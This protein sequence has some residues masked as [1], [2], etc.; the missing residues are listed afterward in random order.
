[1]KIQPVGLYPHWLLTLM[2]NRSL[3]YGSEFDW[4][5]LFKCVLLDK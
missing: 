1:V 4:G 5:I 2:I 3:I